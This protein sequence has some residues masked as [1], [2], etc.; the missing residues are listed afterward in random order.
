MRNK[1]YLFLL[2]LLAATSLFTGCQDMNSRVED[3]LN[4]I[5]QHAEDLDSAVNR[6]LD[7][8]ENL[9]STITSKTRKI[10]DLDSMVRKTT[11]RIDSIVNKSTEEINRRVE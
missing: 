1:S 11:S 5:N 2:I 10:R 6:G 3:Q 7:R 9:D 4:N 8:V